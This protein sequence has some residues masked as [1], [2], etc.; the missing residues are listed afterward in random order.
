MVHNLGLKSEHIKKVE[1]TE[2]RML[3]WICGNTLMDRINAIRRKFRVVST[4]NK[5]RENR[6]RCWGM[7]V[8]RCLVCRVKE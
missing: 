6:L 4:A 5:L 1:V 7:Y 3:R 2:K 8:E